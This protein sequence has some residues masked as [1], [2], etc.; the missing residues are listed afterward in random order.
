MGPMTIVPR[1]EAILL[2]ALLL[3]GA[4]DGSALAQAP[5]AMLSASPQ[6]PEEARIALLPFENLSDARA[7]V[8]EIRR[9]LRGALLARRWALLDEEELER[10]LR[11]HRVRDLSGLSRETGMAVR[12]ETGAT[13]VLVT[14]V[15]LYAENDPPKLAMTC[16]LIATGSESRILWM[17]TAG[18]AGDEAPGFLGLGRVEDPLEVRARVTARLAESLTQHLSG[19]ARR[20]GAA[21]PRRGPRRFRPRSSFRSPAAPPG[22]SG[23]VRIAVLPF[24]DESATRHAGDI[25][26]LQVLRS[27]VDA[28]GIEV[29]EP[30]VVREVLLNARLI[31]EGGPSIPQADLLRALLQV[32]VVVFGEVTQYVEPGPGTADPE[33]EFSLRAID[34]ARRQVIWSSVSHGRGDDRVFFFNVGRIATAHELAAELARAVIGEFLPAVTRAS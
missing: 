5:G 4:A 18:L 31:Q 3:G 19:A 15:D 12:E 28:G 7:P 8:D 6:A 26:W 24:S 29:I 23:P 1:R 17:G 22:G 14:S 11:R 34:A 33:I 30:G 16:R 21:E 32:D 13:A 10:L 9:A 2:S 27:L 20:A 25:L